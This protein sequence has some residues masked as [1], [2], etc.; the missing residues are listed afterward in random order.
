MDSFC[1]LLQCSNKRSSTR[2]PNGCLP[3]DAHHR[4]SVDIP[5]LTRIYRERERYIYIYTYAAYI[6]IYIYMH[7]VNI[8]IYPSQSRHLL[9]KLIKAKRS[10]R[11]AYAD[12]GSLCLK[13]TQIKWARLV[14]TYMIY[15]FS[16]TVHKCVCACWCVVRM[17]FAG[18][19]QK[20]NELSTKIADDCITL[21]DIRKCPYT[22]C[23]PRTSH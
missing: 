20:H 11:E 2:Q 4:S 9:F 8:C 22:V 12:K 18:C 7:S 1:S 10:L 5:H 15:F 23:K 13:E 17:T 16:Y 21:L 6:Y 19:F 14:R 3:G